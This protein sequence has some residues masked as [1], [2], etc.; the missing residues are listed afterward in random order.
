MSKPNNARLKLRTYLEAQGLSGIDDGAGGLRLQC[1][2]DQ[3]T[4][5]DATIL[6]HRPIIEGAKPIEDYL[7]ALT[8]GAEIP[9]AFYLTDDE[10]QR[11]VNG[12][13]DLE[14]VKTSRS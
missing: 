10:M 5:R 14:Y 11:A 3:I 7:G 1:L 8:Q 12:L 6:G 9:P 13:Y 4:V 2:G